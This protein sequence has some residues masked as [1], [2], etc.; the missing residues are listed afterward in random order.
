MRAPML[1]GL[2][3]RPEQRIKVTTRDGRTYDLG[4]QVEGTDPIARW[5][6]WR[7]RARIAAYCRDRLRTLT[8]MER[9]EFIREMGA[10]RG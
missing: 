4:R 7:Q 3:Q 9:E 10:S 5:F 8:P 2:G 6:Q 1:I